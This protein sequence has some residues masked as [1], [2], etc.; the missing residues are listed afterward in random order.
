VTTN[1]VMPASVLLSQ[2]KIHCGSECGNSNADG[3]FSAWWSL[4]G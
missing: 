2:S 3:N 1:R 4:C